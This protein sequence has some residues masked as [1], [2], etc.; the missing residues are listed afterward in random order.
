MSASVLLLL[1]LLCASS[2][3]RVELVFGGD[4]IPHGEVKEVARLHARAGAPPPEG[5]RAPSLN[6]EG[7]DHV[8]GPIADVLRTADVGVVNL[9]TPV[10][11]NKKAVARELLFN[12]PSAMVH[13]LASAGVKVVSTA[14][15]HA[16]DQHPAGMLETLR[17]LDAA[18]IRH[19]GTGATKDAAWEPAFVDVRGVKVGFLSFT[20]M[21]NGFSNPKDAQ[22]PHVALV[23]YAG[24]EAH[25]GMQP[26]QV[27]E[28]VRAAAARC[29]ALIVLAHWGTE[30]K[31]EPRP[32]DRELGRA[33]LDAGA[34]AV[35]G[36]HPHVLQP[37]ESYQ[38]VDGRKGL[39]AYSLGNLVA[40]QDRFYQHEA[41]AKRS[42]GDRRD[43]M[44]LRLS[45]VRP[46]P[47][48]SVALEEV[49]VLPVWIENNAVGR[50]R[51]ESRNIQPVL[52]DREVEEVTA[53]LALLAARPAPLDKETRA[54]K[55][56][57]ER[58]LEGSK[59]R[60]ER[61]LRMLPEGFAVA[62]PELRRRGA[63]TVP[64]GRLASQP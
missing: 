58:R 32:E 63:E 45:L 37:L 33:L 19:T 40:N 42:G 46:M 27:V 25:R 3:T 15:N 22:A 60:R 53:R 18:G 16:R 62:P 50:A 57:L 8:F 14:N 36:H 41:G 11:D 31:G 52:I 21:L 2:P 59:H 4:V 7:W 51:N 43:S 23:P 64:A 1:P 56:L 54:Q 35:I 34:R 13:A 28:A 61:I 29:D 39:I 38:T 30:Y 48:V 6:H 55:A 20:R 10:T 47:G 49:A 26:E 12:A 9:E 17:H 5:G 44:L 24:H